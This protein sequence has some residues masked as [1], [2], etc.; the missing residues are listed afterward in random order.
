MSRSQGGDAYRDFPS[1]GESDTIRK[2]HALRHCLLADSGGICRIAEWA[3]E[4]GNNIVAAEDFA[5]PLAWPRQTV[6]S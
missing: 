3:A 5:E 1:E 2:P 4:D 6:R